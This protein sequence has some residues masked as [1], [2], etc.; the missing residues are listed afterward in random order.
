[1]GC[2][3]RLGVYSCRSLSRY[4]PTSRFDPTSPFGSIVPFSSATSVPVV[5]HQCSWFGTAL[6]A[7]AARDRDDV[8][9]HGAGGKDA[10][11][12]F[13]RRPACPNLVLELLVAAPERIDLILQIDDLLDPDEVDS[14]VL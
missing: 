5:Q 12:A 13:L 14:L 6:R 3:L 9:A 7:T 4:G 11:I 8:S 10:C 2:A 1:M